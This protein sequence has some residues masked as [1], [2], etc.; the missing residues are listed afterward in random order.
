ML[1][2][3]Q[4]KIKTKQNKKCHFQYIST[5]QTRSNGNCF[6]LGDFTNWKQ[7]IPLTQLAPPNADLYALEDQKAIA[8]IQAQVAANPTNNKL[9]VICVDKNA[10][11]HASKDGDCDHDMGVSVITTWVGPATHLVTQQ[12][13]FSIP[14]IYFFRCACRNIS[15]LL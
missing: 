11:N 14:G 3:K 2:S 1:K 12:S 5:H 4:N 6:W 10:C 8:F 13:T 9:K 15:D 7:A